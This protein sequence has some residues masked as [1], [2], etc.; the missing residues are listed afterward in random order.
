[1]P[2]VVHVQRSVYVPLQ[3]FC[4][5]HQDCT[6][7]VSHVSVSLNLCGVQLP[8]RP[9]CPS[10]TRVRL[11]GFVCVFSFVHALIVAKCACFQ[12]IPFSWTHTAQALDTS[13]MFYGAS[14]FSSN[15]DS[16]QVGK[17]TT[18]AN[19]FYLASNF[20]SPSESGML[21]SLLFLAVKVND[22]F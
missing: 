2:V 14:A 21:V 22:R 8:S 7:L 19:M 9:T 10:G 13:E 5:F 3:R 6:I 16:W 20:N 17:V 15:L 1:M 18:M 12:S 4:A 11:F